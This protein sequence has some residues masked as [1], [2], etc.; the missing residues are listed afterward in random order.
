MD[1]D[2]ARRAKVLAA[3]K[4]LK[5]FQSRKGDTSE[6][7]TIAKRRPSGSTTSSISSLVSA[8]SKNN[9]I[10]HRMTGQVNS[11]LTHSFI[12][13]NGDGEAHEPQPMTPDVKP[14]ADSFIGT[15]VTPLGTFGGETN[16]EVAK[17][18]ER[19]GELEAN[20]RIME[21]KLYNVNTEY[22][23]TVQELK[24]LDPV[25]TA[26]TQKQLEGSQRAVSHLRQQLSLAEQKTDS[27]EYEISGL[28]QKLVYQE[29]D[30]SSLRAQLEKSEEQSQ[31]YGDLLRQSNKRADEISEAS[32]QYQKSAGNFE[33]E[34]VS[35]KQDL[36]Q[37]LTDISGRD[38]I[39]SELRESLEEQTKEL[40]SNG[41]EI[42][43]GKRQLKALTEKSERLSKE[44]RIL[45]DRVQEL[46]QAPSKSQDETPTGEDRSVNGIHEP[47]DTTKITQLSIAEV[48]RALETTRNELELEKQRTKA[49][50]DQLAA[51]QPQYVNVA[52]L[53]STKMPMQNLELQLD[54]EKTK[55]RE[56]LGQ[57]ESVRSEMAELRRRY[58]YILEENKQLNE[59]VEAEVFEGDEFG[60]GMKDF[61]VNGS[62]KFNPSSALSPGR[63]AEY[64]QERRRIIRRAQANLLNL[65]DRT[66]QDPSLRTLE[67]SYSDIDSLRSGSPYDDHRQIPIKSLLPPRIKPRHQAFMDVPKCS[68]CI[69]R[70][71]EI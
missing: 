56:L 2:E 51:T 63:Y 23:K 66:I 34:F 31:E 42:S 8:K 37:A 48:E 21:S 3:K 32:A 4:K 10:A 29:E 45:F 39:I 70:A 40:V 54:V 1:Q 47:N 60:A 57:L 25:L 11:E 44:N 22:Q 6:G 46:Q 13:Y 16:Q 19:I 30:L 20:E 50:A 12:N 35:N 52:P 61:E 17:L 68:G 58:M 53:E 64:E 33:K 36:Q 14:A 18:I 67:S 62:V 28:R 26:S 55:S 5:K 59:L 65:Q 7:S 38:K 15:P 41:K 9:D 69:G 27:M 71:I 49:L 24:K 43:N